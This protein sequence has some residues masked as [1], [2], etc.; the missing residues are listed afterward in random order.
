MDESYL[1]RLSHSL[2]P[3]NNGAGP[4]GRSERLRLR[5]PKP[6]FPCDYRGLTFP[7][8]SCRESRIFLSHFQTEIGC[9]LMLSQSENNQ[10]KSTFDEPYLLFA[11]PTTIAQ[12]F[13]LYI[14]LTATILDADHPGRFL[15]PDLEC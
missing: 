5:M 9:L 8:R 14:V 1:D 4:L 7:L 3:W 2:S 10:L 13:V 15:A 12:F 6:P 11:T